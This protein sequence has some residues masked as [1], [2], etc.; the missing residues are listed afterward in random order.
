MLFHSQT[1][2]LIFLPLAL[3]G[4]YLLA[5]HRRA[6]AWLLIAASLVFYGFWDPRLVP[7]LVGSVSA[8]WLLA[9]AFA[10]LPRGYLAAAGIVLNLAVLGIFKY[11]D[12]FAGTL[13][14]LAGGGHQPWS[15]VLP[16]GISFFTFQQISYLADL[17]RGRARAY[18][19]EEYALYVT[20]FPQLI[21]GP[22]V[23][24]NELIHQFDLE[25][26]R[27]GLHE[28]LSRGFVLLVVGLAKKVL[29]ANQLA[30]V[31][32]PVFA[33]AAGGEPVGFAAA[34]VATLAFTFQIYFDF[35]AYSDMAI[36]LGLMFGFTLPINFNAPYRAASIREFWRRWHMTLTR[37]LTDYVYV[38]VGQ[39]LP[40][41]A[42][43]DGWLR[44]GI[45]SMVTMVLCGLW[46]GAAW[47][48]VVWG[49]LHGA[50]LV[51]NQAWRR[52]RLPMPAV[53]GWLLTFLFFALGM[54]LFRA[55]DFATA[56]DMLAVMAGADG[57]QLAVP[58]IAPKRLVLV[59]VAALLC[60]LAPTSQRL[61]MELFSPRRVGA[62]AAAGLLVYITLDVGGGGNAEFI[63]FQF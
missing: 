36:G 52:A 1:F 9:R 53:L 30:L 62:A 47:T 14:A 48:F 59:G 51:V 10:R 35:S 40:F 61:A 42:R 39:R 12:F 26:L 25:P 24:H 44:E 3:V 5:A 15:I 34:W 43:R 56:L 54:V 17:G 38:P 45:A 19:F 55:A 60:F 31:A 28:R 29:I 7:L 50:A 18:R 11:A 46:H 22:I 63:Y 32:D 13:A 16:L 21:A 8:N 20:F 33:A 57:W 41:G 37:F 49:G 2:L 58:G 27:D 4:Y 23:R 6:R